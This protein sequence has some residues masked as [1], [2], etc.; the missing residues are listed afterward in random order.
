MQTTNEDVQQQPRQYGLLRN[1]ARNRPPAG[2][3]AN[4]R[5]RSTGSFPT[6]RSTSLHLG[7][8][9]AA[10]HGVGR[11]VKRQGTPS[12]FYTHRTGHLLVG[13]SG[14]L[15]FHRR[16]RTHVDLSSAAFSTCSFRPDMSKF[17][18]TE[19]LR[20]KNPGLASEGLGANI[21]DLQTS[22]H[23]LH[24]G[25]SP[26]QPAKCNNRQKTHQI[27]ASNPVLGYLVTGGT[28]N[29]SSCETGDFTFMLVCCSSET[30]ILGQAKALLT[31]MA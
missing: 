9:N 12:A 25:V 24:S 1:A 22:L 26:V 3:Q 14:N 31:R 15:S 8:R 7:Y 28:S 5:Y 21:K 20:F 30:P 4:D 27:K 13:W 6:I 17:L 29:E 2:L 10:G 16:S 23:S 11:R 19:S 18:D